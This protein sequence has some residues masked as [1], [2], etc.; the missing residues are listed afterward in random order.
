MSGKDFVL[1]VIFWPPL[2]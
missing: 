2:I 1:R